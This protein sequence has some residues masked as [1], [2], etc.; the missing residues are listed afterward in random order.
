MGPDQPIKDANGNYTLARLSDAHDNAVAVATEYVDEN[1]TDRFQGNLYGEYDILKDLKFRVT[2][3]AS[4][5][6]GRT[7]IYSYHFAGG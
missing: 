7:G 4:A 2:F 3:G 1:V 5:N 6:N